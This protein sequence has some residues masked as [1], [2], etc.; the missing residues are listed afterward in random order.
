VIQADGYREMRDIWTDYNTHQ[1]FE[2]E[3]IN[4]KTT[5]LLATQTLLFAA[6]GVTFA[7]A[8][9]GARIDEFRLVIA[10]SGLSIALIVLVGVIALIRSKFRSWKAYRAFYLDSKTVAPPRPL[11]TGPLE[12]GVLT[13]NTLVTLLPDVLLPLVFVVAWSALA[14]DSLATFIAIIFLMLGYEPNA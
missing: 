8:S 2:H 1:A 7:S 13:R 12:W 3:L 5:W 9:V 4:R 11:D 14:R 10:Y 6:Y